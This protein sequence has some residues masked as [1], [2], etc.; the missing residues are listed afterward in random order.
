MSLARLV[1]PHSARA[2]QP[3][4]TDLLAGVPGSHATRAI[5]ISKRMY[6]LTVPKG[7]KKL[8]KNTDIN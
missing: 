4:H 5:A 2:Q 6:R 3:R 1:L 8:Q 7:S